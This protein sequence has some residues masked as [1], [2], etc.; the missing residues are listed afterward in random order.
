MQRVPFK[1][2]L[3]D[4]VLE[5][6]AGKVLDV[7]ANGPPVVAI[8]T[9]AAVHPDAA[10]PVATGTT[11]EGA[12]ASASAVP[13]AATAKPVLAKSASSKAEASPK[14]PKASPKLK[15]SPK[16]KQAPKGEN[17]GADGADAPAGKGSAKKP[18]AKKGAAK[19]LHIDSKLVGDNLKIQG[20]SPPSG[21]SP[22][23]LASL[24]ATQE[25]HDGVE[26]SALQD[27]LL[28]NASSGRRP[29]GRLKLRQSSSQCCSKT[30]LC[31]APLSAA[32]ARARVP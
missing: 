7:T 14:P 3:N 2:K 16:P 5:V 21:L 22:V 10:A 17:A 27:L 8:A 25:I 32:T 28:A 1:G 19:G 29:L 30:Q 31:Q 26:F 23:Q 12:E 15:P 6:T 24:L 9:V 11:E 13:K 4:A 18:R 20:L